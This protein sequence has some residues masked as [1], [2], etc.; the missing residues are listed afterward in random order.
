[1]SN[2]IVGT[3]TQAPAGGEVSVLLPGKTAADVV[4][5]L[6]S[7][8]GA[9]VGDSVLV[10]MAGSQAWAVGVLGAVPPPR[11][12]DPLATVDDAPPTSVEMRRTVTGRAALTPSWTGTWRA[13]GWRSDTQDLFQGDWSGRGLNAGAAFIDGLDAL[14]VLTEVTIHLER[15][16]G[17]G[18]SASQAP[19]MVLLGSGKSAGWPTVLASAAGPALAWGTST[20]WEVPTSWL[21]L[22]QSGAATG[23]GIQTSTA[24]PYIKISGSRLWA[25]ATWER[26]S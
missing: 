26:T 15:V 13:G 14:G 22:M 8:T 3:I 18:A 19:T 4:P 25:T 10:L 21:S 9:Q 17:A 1:M 12:P 23:V 2:V 20:D 24:Q 16:S 5:C 11:P 7:M 6:R